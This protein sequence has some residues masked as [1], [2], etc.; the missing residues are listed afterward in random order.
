MR[1][2]IEIERKSRG[3]LYERQINGSSDSYEKAVKTRGSFYFP[4]RSKT[5]DYLKI[6]SSPASNRRLRRVAEAFA[7]AWDNATESSHAESTTAI[8]IKNA[9]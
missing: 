4:N 3:R 5:G 2:V 8:A 6:S 7:A 9:L 1:S